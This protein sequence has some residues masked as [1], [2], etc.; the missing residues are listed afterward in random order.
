MSTYL[1]DGEYGSQ[2]WRNDAACARPEH[3]HLDWF[4]ERG[5]DVRHLKAICNAC[6]VRT[7]CLDTALRNHETHGIWGGMSER[8]RRSERGKRTDTRRPDTAARIVDH[9]RRFGAHH[10]SLAQLTE[11]MGAP[12]LD[13][14]LPLQR[15]EARGV[16]IVDP[17]AP[18]RRGVAIR[19]IALAPA[20]H[21]G[22]TPCA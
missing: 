7:D 6:P 9:L 12:G 14:S 15:L 2:T 21:E 10:G 16:V 4:P 18:R 20:H 8:Q 5:K 19:R 22:T 3:R 11:A 13:A 1:A 17:P